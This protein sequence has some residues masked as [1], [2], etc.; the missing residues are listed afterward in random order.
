MNST[1]RTG[2]LGLVGAVAGF[3]L[4]GCFTPQ[5]QPE[6]SVTITS[7]GLGLVPYYTQLKKIDATGCGA[8]TTAGD[9]DHMYVGMQR[10]RTKASGGDFTVALKPSFLADPWLGYSYSADYDAYNNCVYEESCNGE[11]DPTYSCVTDVLADGGVELYDGRPVDTATPGMGFGTVTD[12]GGDFEVDLTN[13][14]G[15]VEEPVYRVD[16]T[17]MDGKSLNIIAN[18]PQFPTAGKCALT[19]TSGGT[20]NYEAVPTLTGAPLPAITYKVEF[21]DTNVI[22]NAEFPGIAFTGKVKLT[23]GACVANYNVV[24][25]WSGY[26]TGTPEIHCT[27]AAGSAAG[28]L[29]YATECDPNADLDAGRLLGS[30]MAP[31]FKPQCQADATDP[32]SGIC[33]PTVDLTAVK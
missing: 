25:W 11:D 2:L 29:S 20:Q 28:S 17:D 5:P 21:S 24:A 1:I 19:Q 33:V 16:P 15:S 10:F 18:M 9:L 22:N 32:T 12:P 14:C 8:G 13:L 27:P 30:G 26:N 31:A 7:A 23:E 4:Q 3:G 6:C